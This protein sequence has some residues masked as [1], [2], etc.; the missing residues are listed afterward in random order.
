MDGGI[1]EFTYEAVAARAGTSRPVLYRRWPQRE[2][3]LKSAI[4][5]GGTKL[6]Q[7]T[8]DT[9]SL[10]GDVIEVLLGMN[11]S[12][13]QLLT[14]MS[15]NLEI[16]R[17]STPLPPAEVRDIYLGDRPQRMREIVNRAVARGEADADRATDLVLAAPADLVRNRIM[18]TVRKVSRREVEQI[19]DEVFLPLVA[20]ADRAAS[21]R[22]RRRITT[23]GT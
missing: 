19:V 5:W 15:G 4:R 8:P 16:S 2:Q 1:Q 9:G 6:P 11:K 22:P 13:G 23:D 10:R 3:L 12:V 20:P 18:L 7:A 21:S 14:L 17:S